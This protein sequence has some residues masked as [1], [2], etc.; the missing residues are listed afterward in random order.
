M[1]IFSKEKVQLA[2]IDSETS[3]SSLSDSPNNDA[4][5]ERYCNSKKQK[6]KKTY[7]QFYHMNIF[8]T[9]QNDKSNNNNDESVTEF[10]LFEN[11]NNNKDINLAYLK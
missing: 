1:L 11:P 7:N 9:N 4:N 2:V 8:E 10:S 6:S 3:S 5:E